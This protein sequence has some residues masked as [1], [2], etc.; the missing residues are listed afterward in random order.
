MQQQLDAA[1]CAAARQEVIAAAVDQGSP[2][3][4]LQALPQH[5]PDQAQLAAAVVHP[6]AAAVVAVAG[7]PGARP[8]C[9]QA[10]LCQKPHVQ[11]VSVKQ[12][13]YSS[14][15]L[16]EIASRWTTA[17]GVD[18]CVRFAYILQLIVLRAICSERSQVGVY[19]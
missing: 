1:Q 4:Q 18:S 17:L 11:A 5:W 15:D 9:W 6:V 2:G 7:V 10:G 3:G 8:P 19:T 13:L 12:D 16:R 14:T